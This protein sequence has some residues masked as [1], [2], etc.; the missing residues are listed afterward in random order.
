MFLVKLLLTAVNSALYWWGGYDFVAARRFIMPGVIALS[1]AVATHW[2]LGIPVIYGPMV[3]CLCIGYG[4]KSVLY[5]L[6]GDA[7]A[8]GIWMALVA[9]AASLGL[10]FS[11]HL[12][13][14]FLI[15]Y[16]V[17]NG[18]FGATLKDLPQTIGDPIYGA[19]LGSILFLV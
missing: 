6:F 14:Y 17:I 2:W 5:K 9:A 11:G 19:S 15:P 13:L 7:G 1:C 3:G 18:V 12:H 4:E 8:R 16:I 10:F